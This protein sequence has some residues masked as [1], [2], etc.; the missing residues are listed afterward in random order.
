MQADS[1]TFGAAV[2]FGHGSLRTSS[3]LHCLYGPL[4]KSA[5]RNAATE[6]ISTASRLSRVR[7]F[8]T[9]WTAA[10][11]APLSMKFSRQEY[12]SVLSSPPS[13]DLPDLGIKPASPVLLALQ[14]DSLPTEPSGKP[15][16]LN[17]V[18]YI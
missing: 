8:V 17:A 6:L 2:A 18:C 11:Q 15:R 4:S 1:W 9:P 7:L 14:A 13:G 10:C 16:D 12:W 3:G 5:L